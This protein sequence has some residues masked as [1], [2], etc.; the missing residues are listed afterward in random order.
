MFRGGIF[1][2]IGGGFSRYSTDR[3][4]LVP[5]FEK[6][7]YDNALLA[8]A[9]L[10]A[11]ERTGKTIYSSVARRVFQYLERELKAPDGGFFSAQDADSDGVEGKFYLLSKDELIALLGREDGEQ[12][13]RYFGIT[14]QGNHNGKSIPNLLSSPEPDNVSEALLPKVYE[15]RRTR[16]VLG[17]DRKVLTAWNSL[18]AA[19]YAMAARILKDDGYLCT[20][21]STLG[22]LERELTDEDR[23]Y[24]GV[25]DGHRAGYGFLDDYAFTIFALIQMHQTTMEE[26]FL[27]R[28]V[29]LA[30]KT[31]SAF[32]GRGKR[33]LFL[34]RDGQ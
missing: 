14:A 34:C 2:H 19:A 13:C 26:T 30:E 7:L 10:L 11:Y 20:A 29:A 31:I 18:A 5:H 32:W 17:T 21:R 12:F 15:Y 1:D 8:M 22:F 6:M 9:Y 16:T 33:R 28:A 27:T 3:Y 4:W 25:T 24:A 23:V